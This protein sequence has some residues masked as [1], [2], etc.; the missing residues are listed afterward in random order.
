[1]TV[2]RVGKQLRHNDKI[3]F[4]LLMAI[5]VNCV[6]PKIGLPK[7]SCETFKTSFFLISDGPNVRFGSV[8]TLEPKSSVRFGLP[9]S[10]AI[11]LFTDTKSGDSSQQPSEVVYDRIFGFGFLPTTLDSAKIRFLPNPS[12]IRPNE[13]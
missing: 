13:S 7:E 10:S 1:M 5:K 3:V 4:E 12:K 9:N 6:F 11:L 8:S 2:C